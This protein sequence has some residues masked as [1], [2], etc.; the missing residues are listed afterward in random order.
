[1]EKMI[2]QLIETGKSEQIFENAIQGYG[3]GQVAVTH[4]H[5]LKQ[6]TSKSYH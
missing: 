2:D 6:L 5:F 1:M 3:R 4:V